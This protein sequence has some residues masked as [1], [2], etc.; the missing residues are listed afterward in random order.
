MTVTTEFKWQTINDG[1]NQIVFTT[2]QM[3]ISVGLKL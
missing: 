2:I 1:K 3:S